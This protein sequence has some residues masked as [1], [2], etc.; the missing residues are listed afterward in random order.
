M[1]ASDYTAARRQLHVIAEWLLAGPQHAAS[2]TIRLEAGD[3]TIATVADPPVSV[4]AA[5]LTYDG[6]TWPLRG[7]VRQLGTSAGL[8]CERPDVIYHDAVPGDCTTT[9]DASVEAF[10]AVLAVYDVGAE[11]LDSFSSETPILWPE[12]FDLSVRTSN[13]NFGVSPG[14]ESS[15][16]PYAYVGPDAVDDS[17]FWNAPFGAQLLID[18]ASPDCVAA[19]VAFFEQGLTA[20]TG[21]R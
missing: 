3:G 20:A 15:A 10:E 12:H 5:G 13:V 16:L 4:A 2:G 19:I 7:T 6:S 21:P 9:L 18:P 17:P 11:A 8:A 1:D 14:D